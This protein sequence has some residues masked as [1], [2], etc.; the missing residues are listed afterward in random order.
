M[1]KKIFSKVCLC[2]FILLS[3][4]ISVAKA[5]NF[6]SPLTKLDGDEISVME[7][8]G[9]KPVY[10]KFWASWCKQCMKEMPHLQDSFDAYGKDVEV[11]SINIGLNETDPNIRK[12]IE[13]FKLNLPI[14]KDDKGALAREL[15][16]IG[17]PFH[18]L[19]DKEGDIVH[20]GHEASEELDRKLNILAQQQQNK[21]PTIVIENLVGE[22]VNLN[23]NDKDYTA[24]YLTSTWCDWYLADTR[25]KMS[26]ACIEGQQLA[27]Q[28]SKTYSDVNWQTLTSH[29]WTGKEELHKYI[30]KYQVEMPISIDSQGDA[31]FNYKIKQLS[32]L[33]LLKGSKVIGRT[34]DIDM[35]E[36]LLKQTDR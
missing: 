6:S 24:L 32:T 11:F 35:F 13:N 7:F 8:I 21:L 19:I 4:Y 16:F 34:N 30:E 5:A 15:D 28:L 3:L 23:F 31:F 29:L 14:Y 12:V 2:S 10:L 20:K 18:V 9:K 27:N 22:A 25:P 17:T 33:V 36:S 26:L 1:I